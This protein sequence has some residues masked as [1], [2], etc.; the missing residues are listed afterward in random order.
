MLGG[1][2]SDTPTQEAL[3]AFPVLV[4]TWLLGVAFAEAAPVDAPEMGRVCAFRERNEM[5]FAGRVG[6]R[7]GATQI[8]SL[9]PGTFHCWD[10]PAGPHAYLATTEVDHVSS[11]V[12][13]AGDTLYLR[14]RIVTGVMVGG[15]DLVPSTGGARGSGQGLGSC[16]RAVAAASRE[17]A[18]GSIWCAPGPRVR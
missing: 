4:L 7:E 11:V 6:L 12:V 14:A 1:L 9:T 8:A 16:Q 2:F 13:P 3:V 10:T 5:G 18:T 15:A 17:A